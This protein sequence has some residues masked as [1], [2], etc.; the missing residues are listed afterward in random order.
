MVENTSGANPSDPKNGF[1][2]KD[3][4][5]ILLQE[6][7][8]IRQEVIHRINNF[9]QAMAFATVLLAWLLTQQ[10][11]GP[12]FWVGALVLVLLV[13]FFA[14]LILRD[15]QRMVLRLMQI[16]SDVNALVGIEVLEWETYWGGGGRPGWFTIRPRAHERLG[17]SRRAV[18]QDIQTHS[19][20]PFSS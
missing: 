15:Q 13:G 17:S 4:V 14:F 20:A 11:G 9:Y 2:T 16:E 18:G 8:T 12:R 1:S 3:V 7:N 6:Y 10:P 5:Q 19:K